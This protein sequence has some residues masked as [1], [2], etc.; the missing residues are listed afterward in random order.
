MIDFR[1]II[2]SRH[3]KAGAPLI[4]FVVGG[5]FVLKVYREV[6]VDLRQERIQTKRSKALEKVLGLEGVNK[7]TVE[8]MHKTFHEKVDIN[9]WENIRAPRP[10]ENDSTDYKELIEKRAEEAKSK[11]TF[12]K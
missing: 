1:K 3:F 2:E 6:I 12:R 8:D 11:W 5:S 7:V 4:I 9:N 10:W